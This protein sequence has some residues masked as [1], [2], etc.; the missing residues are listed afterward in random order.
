MKAALRCWDSL[1][2]DVLKAKS[3]RG[4]EMLRQFTIAMKWDD[5]DAGAGTRG[6]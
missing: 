1:L 6:L 5:L 2:W 4:F 3:I